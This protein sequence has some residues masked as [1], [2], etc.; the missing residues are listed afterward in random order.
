MGGCLSQA[1]RPVSDQLKRE[2][3]SPDFLTQWSYDFSSLDGCAHPIPVGTQHLHAKR[4][5]LVL[6]DAQNGCFIFEF[7]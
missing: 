1:K 7:I 4:P 6:P 5:A 2:T 3:M